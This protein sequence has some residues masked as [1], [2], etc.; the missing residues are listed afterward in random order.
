MCVCVSHARARFWIISREREFSLF[1][2][3]FSLSRSLLVHYSHE[4]VINH[5]QGLASSLT[6]GDFSKILYSLSLKKKKREKKIDHRSIDFQSERERKTIVVFFCAVTLSITRVARVVCLKKKR[7][8]KHVCSR[9]V[10]RLVIIN[11]EHVEQSGEAVGGEI[12]ESRQRK[13]F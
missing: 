13:L 2:F 11:D 3:L 9:R 4:K 8:V 12:G 6:Q 5:S 7:E 10:T 1:S